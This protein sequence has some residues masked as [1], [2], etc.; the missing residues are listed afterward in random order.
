MKN[1]L[2]GLRAGVTFA[3]AIPYTAVAALAVVTITLVRPTSSGLDR[4]ARAWGR[5]WCWAAGVKLVV[6]GLEHIDSNSSY[7]IVS[8]HQ[9]AF[10]IF[11]HFAALPV[12]IRFLAKAELF[13]I[14]LFGLA[15]RRIGMVEV[16]RGA[17]RA[18]H[19]AINEGARRTMDR[20]WSLMIYPE[21]T[22]PRDGVMLPFKKGAFS[23]ARNVRAPVLPTAIVGSRAVWKPK[24]KLIRSGQVT[25]KIMPPISTDGLM[26]Y[27]LEGLKNRVHAMVAEQVGPALLVQEARS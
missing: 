3:V 10:D 22:R 7:V 4:V 20:G 6:E 16:D 14:P 24:T 17:G 1:L 2:G 5:M 18:A 26:I 21:G 8:N 9:S 12:P 25:V 15:M 23:I 11:A 19:Q 13:K 27:E